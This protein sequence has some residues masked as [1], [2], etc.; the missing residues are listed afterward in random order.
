MGL[1]YLTTWFANYELGNTLRCK[2]YGKIAVLLVFNLAGSITPTINTLTLQRFSIVTSAVVFAV[3]FA[4]NVD[5]RGFYSAIYEY[6]LA[7]W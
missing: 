4:S 3:H 7:G 6:R 1:W 2:I 5:V